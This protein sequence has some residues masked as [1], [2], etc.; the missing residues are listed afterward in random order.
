MKRFLIFRLAAFQWT[1]VLHGAQALTP[2]PGSIIGVS[3]RSP[4]T[5]Q[6]AAAEKGRSW[7]VSLRCGAGLHELKTGNLFNR[8]V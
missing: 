8:S 7:N 6:R 5:S 2:A 4:W 3:C 1:C